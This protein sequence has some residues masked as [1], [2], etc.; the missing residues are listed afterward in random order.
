MESFRRLLLSLRRLRR[1]ESGQGLVEFAVIVPVLLF[2][3]FGI[4]EFGRFYFARVT[5]QQAV[6]GI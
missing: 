2:V 4:F 1:S 3:F 5:L 6:V